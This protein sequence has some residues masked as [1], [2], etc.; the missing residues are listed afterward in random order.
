MA[1]ILDW[2]GVLEVSCADYPAPTVAQL[3]AAPLLE[4]WR[5]AFVRRE[6]R[7]SLVGSVIGHPLL[8]DRPDVVTSMLLALDPDRRWART[9]SRIYRLGAEA[10]ATL[11]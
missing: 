9:H 10:E 4:R 11:H 6:R 5:F 2:I 7:P 1:D 3:A 8:G